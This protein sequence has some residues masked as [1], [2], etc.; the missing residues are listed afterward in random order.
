LAKLFARAFELFANRCGRHFEPRG[1][2]SGRA[3]GEVIQDD[4][5]ALRGGQRIYQSPDLGKR[6]LRRRIRRA[7]RL[8]I[9]RLLLPRHLGPAPRMDPSG[10]IAHDTEE[11]RPELARVAQRVEALECADEGLL[12]YVFGVGTATQPGQRKSRGRSDVS[13]HETGEGIS[14]TRQCES[15]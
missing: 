1:N 7:G 8:Q 10:A 2:L 12:G 9:D 14:I 5:L 6:L 11:P 4:N 3:V 15:D 13:I